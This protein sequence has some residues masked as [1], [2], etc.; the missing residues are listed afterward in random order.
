MVEALSAIG[1]RSRM[2]VRAA[3]MC[4]RIPGRLAPGGGPG[5]DGV[6]A[7]FPL[8]RRC[9]RNTKASRPRSTGW[10]KPRQ[11]RPSRWSRPSLSFIGGCIG[12]P[13]QRSIRLRGSAGQGLGEG[14]PDRRREDLGRGVGRTV[15]EG[16]FARAARA[17]LADEPGTP[18][19]RRRS[20]SAHQASGKNKRRPTPRHGP[21]SVR[22]GPGRWPACRA[23]RSTAASPPPSAGRPSPARCRP[24]PA[25]RP[26]GRRPSPARPPEMPWPKA[27]S[28]RSEAAAGC[29]RGRC[30]SP[31]ARCS[32]HAPGGIR[33][34]R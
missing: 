2:R 13:I 25:P 18:T 19:A 14:G 1:Q 24:R 12:S 3:T 10:C 32:R 26:A 23:G 27:R 22:P 31:S 33:P 21:G 6:M 34:L 20:A 28:R 29:R 4:R 16:V 15:G 11:L 8:S 5:S 30:G 7:L 17:V 9:W